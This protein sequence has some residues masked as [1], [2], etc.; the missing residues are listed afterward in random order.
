MIYFKEFEGRESSESTDQE[1]I[2]N[3]SRPLESLESNPCTDIARVSSSG[4]SRL[5]TDFSLQPTIPKIPS[6]DG[7]DN[8]EML[9]CIGYLLEQDVGFANPEVFALD[10]TISFGEFVHGQNQRACL[11]GFSP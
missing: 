7:E 3:H 5:H 1:I 10:S 9:G 4:A 8:H 2:A 11:N 6:S